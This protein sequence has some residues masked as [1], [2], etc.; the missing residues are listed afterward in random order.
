MNKKPFIARWETEQTAV[1]KALAAVT[2]KRNL[3]KKV[4]NFPSSPFGL[5]EDGLQDF[6]GIVLVEII[7]Y[8]TVQKL[9]LSYASF[10]DGTGLIVSQFSHCCFDGMKLDG[11]MVSRQFSHCSFRKV[12]LKNAGISERFE[13][14]D[15][16]GCNLSRAKAIDVTFIRCHFTDVNFRG[17][18][19]MHCRFEDCSFEGAIFHN[20]SLAGSRF[21]GE[22]DM[23]PVW[24]D[25]IVTS[26]KING[27][28]L[29]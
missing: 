15:F 4:R 27:E 10:K 22:T 9:D 25:T 12:S 8:L 5:T 24:G 14:C 2:G 26:V 11:A 28:A 18:M 16:T 1:N 3:H 29:V 23:L 7:Q 19:F 21:M 17:A 6:R 20:S 13:D